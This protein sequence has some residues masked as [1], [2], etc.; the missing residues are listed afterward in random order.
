MHIQ[1]VALLRFEIRMK[2]MHIL[3]KI[4]IYDYKFYN[5]TSSN[6]CP[7]LLI[8]LKIS[9]FLYLPLS[10]IAAHPSNNS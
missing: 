9:L 3:Q 6:Y 8:H 4:T 1:D 5:S 10:N 7:I 2:A